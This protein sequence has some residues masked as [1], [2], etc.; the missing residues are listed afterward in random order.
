MMVHRVIPKFMPHGRNRIAPEM[1]MVLEGTPAWVY[2][3]RRADRMIIQQGNCIIHV[4]FQIVVKS[5]AYGRL[6]IL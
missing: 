6:L 5:K 2:H 4:G 3:E 1:L